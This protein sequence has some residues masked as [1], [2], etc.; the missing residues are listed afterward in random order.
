MV[1]LNVSYQ[2]MEQEAAGLDS[3]REEINGQLNAVRTRIQNLTTS[4][5]VTDSA[6]GKY[7]NIIEQF[8]A[9]AAQTIDSLSD[10]STMLRQTAATL[11][12]TD[13]QIASQMGG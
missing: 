11:Q 4:G 8:T 10:L 7:M 9:G 12:D 6:S 13:Q 2:D 3:T 1:N 5:F